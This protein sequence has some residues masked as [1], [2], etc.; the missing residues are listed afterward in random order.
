VGVGGL[1]GLWL[2]GGG[3]MLPY[4]CGGSSREKWAIVLWWFEKFIRSPEKTKEI[5]LFSQ[6]PDLYP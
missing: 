5:I 3:R 1:K 4:P 2:E 6:F